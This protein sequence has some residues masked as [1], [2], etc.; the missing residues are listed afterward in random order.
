M[1]S[2]S[3]LGG[4]IFPIMVERLVG[5][6]GFGWTMRICAFLIAFLLIIANLTVKSRIPPSPKPLDLMEFVRPLTEATYLLVAVGCFLFFFGLF[7]PFNFI[8]L[9]A[10]ERGMSSNL[11]GYLIPILNAAR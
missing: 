7:L 10:R 3:S 1:A 5:Q 4:V 6:V 11:A 2:G 8:I 9:Q